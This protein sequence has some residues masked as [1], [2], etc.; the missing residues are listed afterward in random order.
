[1]CNFIKTKARAATLVISEERG[2]QQGQNSRG[3]H[4]TC[5]GVRAGIYVHK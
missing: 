5:C 4:H 2:S 1:M 3:Q